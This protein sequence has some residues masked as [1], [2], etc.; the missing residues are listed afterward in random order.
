VI[1]LTP[2][3]A[4]ASSTSDPGHGSIGLR[5]II[6]QSIDEPNRSKQPIRSS[7]KPF[8]GPGATPSIRVSPAE[9]TASMPSQTRGSL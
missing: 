6:A 4:A 8:A 5:M 9:R 1:V 3:V 7:V 2:W